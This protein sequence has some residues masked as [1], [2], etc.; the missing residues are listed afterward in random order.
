MGRGRKGRPKWEKDGRVQGTIFESGDAEIDRKRIDCIN[1]IL[2]FDDSIDFQDFDFLF[3]GLGN[4]ANRLKRHLISLDC[5]NDLDRIH[6]IIFPRQDHEGSRS[7]S[8]RPV[9]GATS[10][11]RYRFLSEFETASSS[12]ADVELARVVLPDRHGDPIN[13]PSDPQTTESLRRVLEAQNARIGQHAKQELKPK[14]EVSPDDSVSNIGVADARFSDALEL[15]N[16]SAAS[17][18]S[19]IMS[20]SRNGKGHC[21]LAESRF[22]LCNSQ[23]VEARAL[24][25]GDSVFSSR[26]QPL[27]VTAVKL[28]PAQQQPV[29]EMRAG[30]TSANASLL[31]V[32]ASHRIMVQRGSTPQTM[33]ACHLSEGDHVYCSGEKLQQLIEVKTYSHDLEVVE[34]T[35]KPDEPVE[36]LCPAILSKGHGWAKTTR[37]SS[38][39]KRQD[40]MEDDIYSVPA[41]DDSYF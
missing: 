35:F 14:D 10:G 38:G 17:G 32:T 4:R 7:R 40:A 21:F 36:A 22:R 13:F 26:N 33:P 31:T 24:Q 27:I 30:L 19:S 11:F 16:S 5:L 29:V 6:S 3:P 9:Q 25:V 18:L 34:I 12:G 37:R 39:R 20:C 23:L 2:E 28:H 1:K 8:P 15:S 41:T